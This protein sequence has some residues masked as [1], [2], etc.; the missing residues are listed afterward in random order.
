MNLS[1]WLKFVIG[2]AIAYYE[3]QNFFN[4]QILLMRRIQKSNL[5]KNFSAA[6]SLKILNEWLNI[7][8]WKN[9]AEAENHKKYFGWFLY[10]TLSKFQNFFSFQLL[11][12]RGIQCSKK[13]NLGTPVLYW[14]A[15][16]FSIGEPIPMKSMYSAK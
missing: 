3:F 6:F 5:K 12:M 8:S 13:K 4:F 16:A 7:E 11:L 1:N 9:Q 14:L 2:L 10:Q 15:N